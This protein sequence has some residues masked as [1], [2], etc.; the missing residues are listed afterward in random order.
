MVDGEIQP[1]LTGA[2]GVEAAIERRKASIEEMPG[3]ARQLMRGEP[4]IPTL[5]EE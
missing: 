1:G 3:R 4:V 5:M 2:A